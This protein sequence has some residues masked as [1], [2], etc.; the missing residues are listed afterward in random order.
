MLRVIAFSDYRTQD[1]HT[2]VG[3]VA[4]K[5]P[6]LVLYGGDDLKRFHCGGDNLLEKLV[7]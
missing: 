3:H 4:S 1:I 2:L 6:D 7:W 5:K